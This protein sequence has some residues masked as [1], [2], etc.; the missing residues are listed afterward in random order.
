M[1]QTGAESKHTKPGPQTQQVPTPS[2]KTNLLKG[3]QQKKK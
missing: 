1:N 3:K 2:T